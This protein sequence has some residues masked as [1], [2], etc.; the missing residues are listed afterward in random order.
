MLIGWPASLFTWDILFLLPVPWAAPVL[1]PVLISITMISSG[2]FYLFRP[3]RPKRIHWMAIVAGGLI[4]ILSF[5][6]NSQNL[7]AGGM[8]APYP[9]WL[10]ALGEAMGIGAFMHAVLS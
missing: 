10:L 9:W 8:P 5:T 4:V 1:A 6:L 3:A 2:L 7:L